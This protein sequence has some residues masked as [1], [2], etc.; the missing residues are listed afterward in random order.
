M[1]FTL[2]DSRMNHLPPVKYAI[3]LDGWEFG[4]YTLNYEYYTQIF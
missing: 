1:F 3:I 4:L 2:H